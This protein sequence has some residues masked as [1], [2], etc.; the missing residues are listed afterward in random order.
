VTLA[1]GFRLGPYEIL[2]PLGAG[3]MGEVYRAR[4][5]RLDRD[6]AVKVVPSHLADDRDARARFEREARAVAALSHPNI[7][8]IF[9]FGS[10]GGVTYSV[11]ELLRGETL[12]S[13]LLHGPLPRRKTIDVAIALADALGAAHSRGLVHRDLKPENVF[14]TSDGVVKILD[15]GLVRQSAPSRPADS[16]SATVSETTPGTV[17]GTFGYMSPE[18]VRGEPAD[19]RS[20][21]FALGCVLYEMATGDRAFRGETGAETVA[22]VLRDEP[23]ALRD[24]SEVI[25]ESL[26]SIVARCLEKRPADRFQTAQDLAFALRSQSS[27]P[28]FPRPTAP[29]RGGAIDSVAVLPFE[30]SGDDPDS[31]Y[32]SDGIGET[33]TR[34]LSRIGRLRVISRSAVARYR[35]RDVDPR[36]AGRELNVRAVLVGRLTVRGERIAVHAELVDVS[37]GGQIWSQRYSRPLADMYALEEEIASAIAEQLRVKLG[38]VSPS[39]VPRSRGPKAEAYQLYLKGRY[40]WNRRPEPGFID[41]PEYFE[42]SIEA[43]PS[44][45]LPYSGLADCFIT[46]GSWESGLLPPNEAFLKA[47]GLARKALEIDD[48]SAEAHASLGYAL[49][50][51]DWNFEESER[52]LRRSIEL[53]PGYSPA[54]HWLSHLVLPLGRIEESKRES[55]AALAVDPHDFIMNAHMAWH[56]FFAGEYDPAIQ[57]AENLRS[58]SSTHFWSPFFSGLAHEQ[59]GLLAPAI[60]RLRLAAERA[61]DSTYAVAALAHAHGL[62]GDFRE[63]RRLLQDLEENAR[64]RF[65]SAYDFAIVQLGL[66]ANDDALRHIGQAFDERSSWLIHLN[67][68]PRLDPLRTREGFRELVARVGLPSEAPARAGR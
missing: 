36:G 20:D 52:E 38:G 44:F 23:A 64:R 6:V 61:P 13:A 21:I 29:E 59:M 60:D 49:F 10:D 67:V 40:L 9:D 37:D 22:A 47:R 53:D 41:A 42:K 17:L 2:A 39:V 45:A 34:A 4:D 3:G 57:Y 58:I 24:G 26:R 46:F 5:S 14:L 56:H 1:A 55:L 50:H 8:S 66:G 15:F 48:R 63:A 7:L 30:I 28:A 51:Y 54:H 68:D 11:T 25:L 32:L 33:L 31:R 12:R 65:V 27:S 19:G 62:A 16:I 43:D 35:G 18:Q